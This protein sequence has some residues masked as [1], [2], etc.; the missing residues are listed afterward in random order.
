MPEKATGFLTRDNQ[1]YTSEAEARKHEAEM[2]IRLMCGELKPKAIDPDRLL[3][4]LEAMADQI[5]E[6]LNASQEARDHA[7]HLPNPIVS[8]HH[9]DDGLTER[10]ETVQ[11]FEADGHK[12]MPN[13]GRRS[14]AKTIQD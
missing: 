14:S 7:E 12:S 9:A 2:E 4:A 3:P 13:V 8:E 11:Q 5:L 6:Y 1:F 10:D